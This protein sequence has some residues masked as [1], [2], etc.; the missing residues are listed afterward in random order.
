LGGGA[1][2]DADSFACDGIADNR[3]CVVSDCKRFLPLEVCLHKKV[4]FSFLHTTPIGSYDHEKINSD[5]I[6]FAFLRLPPYLHIPW[7]DSIS[8]TL[9]PISSVAWQAETLPL[10]NAFFWHKKDHCAARPPPPPPPKKLLFYSRSISMC[11]PPLPARTPRTH[12]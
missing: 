4:N 3:L 11:R 10:D 8:R 2:T 9:A 7:Q 6:Y 5:N 1:E 12:R